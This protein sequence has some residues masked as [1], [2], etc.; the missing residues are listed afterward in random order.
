[1]YTYNNVLVTK[2]ISVNK[3]LTLEYEKNITVIKGIETICIP[4]VNFI[5]G[6]YKINN[7]IKINENNNIKINE[8]NSIKINENTGI[9]TIDKNIALGNYSFQIEYSVNEYNANYL[10][11]FTVIYPFNYNASLYEFNYGENFKIEP[12]IK[13]EFNKLS[14]F[15]ILPEIDGILINK[16][17]GILTNNIL[18]VGSN[19][20][21]V[22]LYILNINCF[23][24][25]QLLNTILKINILPVIKYS[26]T[27]INIKYGNT[28]L[29]KVPL[30]YPEN[31]IFYSDSNII[32]LNE[33][34][35]FSII[36][37][38]DV[39]IYYFDIIYEINSIKTTTTIKVIINPIFEYKYSEFIFD[40]NNEYFTDMPNYYPKNGIFSIIN[41]PNGITMQK[42]GIINV[43]K[44]T[45]IGSYNLSILYKVNKINLTNTINVKILPQ[46]YYKT[47][48]DLSQYNSYFIGYYK[49][50]NINFESF[51]EI[52]Q[53]EKIINTNKPIFTNKGYFTVQN[54]LC[55][56]NI[57]G[58]NGIM[59]LKNINIGVYCF[60]VNYNILNNNKIYK[61]QALITPLFKYNINNYNKKF[62]DTFTTKPPNVYPEG[63]L[64]YFSETYDFFT[65]DFN[66]G[67]ITCISNAEIN[68]YKIIVFYELNGYIS[69]NE[70]LFTVFPDTYIENLEITNLGKNNIKIN[71]YYNGL[72]IENYD[73]LLINNSD[74]L[75]NYTIEILTDTI[76][77]FNINLNA[78]YKNIMFPINFTIK[79]LPTIN[80]EKEIYYIDFG[81]TYIINKPII[82]YS[83]GYFEIINKIKG[84][85][86]DKLSGEIY[87]F[88]KLSVNNYLITINYILNDVI[89]Q[90]IVN[91]I[92]KPIIEYTLTTYEFYCGQIIKSEI[93]KVNPQNGKFS[94]DTNNMNID[95]NNMNID[96]NNGTIYFNN[97]N[98]GLY[99]FNVIYTLNSIN[100]SVN[101]NFLIK[102]IINYEEKYFVNYG[103]E[104]LINPLV[105]NPPNYLIK[106]TNLPLNIILNKNT[107]TIIVL[108]N[109][110]P[111]IYLIELKYIVNDIE[112]I[113]NIN[114]IVDPFLEKTKI[115][116]IIHGN[117]EIINLHNSEMNIM[118]N[119]VNKIDKK[120]FYIKHNKL[121]INNLDIGRYTLKVNYK[122]NKLSDE[123]EYIINVNPNLVYKEIIECNYGDKIE[124]LPIEYSPSNGYFKLINNFFIINKFGCIT[125]KQNT[126]LTINIYDINVE[127][128]F[129]KI[130][131]NCSLQVKIN[132][133][134]KYDN[135]IYEGIQ[136]ETL[137]ISPQNFLPK[138]LLFSVEPFGEINSL[139]N[140]KLTNLNIGKYTLKVNYDI[141][142]IFLNVLIK[143]I[144]FYDDNN[145][146]L[147]FGVNKVFIP[148][149]SQNNGKFYFKHNINGFII[150]ENTGII[151][152][153]NLLPDVYNIIVY[154][155]YENIQV[156]TTL[157]IKVLPVLKYNNNNLL[158]KYKTKI[159]I[160][161]PIVNP[162]G[163]IFFTDINKNNIYLDKNNGNISIDDAN[164]GNYNIIINYLY[165]KQVISHTI[166]FDIIPDIAYESCN[167]IFYNGVENKIEKPNVNPNNGKFLLNCDMYLSKYII[168][169]NNGSMIISSNIN[170]GN[171]DFSVLYEHS[172]IQYSTKISLNIYP[173]LFYNNVITEYQ[174][175]V[176]IVEPNFTVTNHGIYDFYLV[177]SNLIIYSDGKITNFNCLN[178]G[179][180]KIYVNYKYQ[181]KTYQ[182]YFLC[183]IEPI[184][185][186]N[187]KDKTIYLYPNN[188]EL[189]YDNKYFEF[190][191]NNIIYKNIYDNIT[192]P[193]TY[194]LNNVSKKIFIQYLAKP[195]KVFDSEINIIYNTNKIINSYV[196]LGIISS[197]DKP[198]NLKIDNLNLNVENLDIGLYSFTI[199]Y[200]V[201]NLTFNQNIKLTIFPKF[202]YQNKYFELNSNFGKIC[203]NPI[204][205]P[206]NG[207]VYMK[208]FIKNFSV[209]N[210]GIISLFNAIPNF[211]NLTIQYTVNNITSYDTVNI[212]C[213][214]TLT[215]ESNSYIIKYGQPFIITNFKC[216]PQSG[217]FTSSISI[218]NYNKNEIIF[219]YLQNLNIGTHNINL[220]Y[221][222]NNIKATL[223]ITVYIEPTI[224]YLNKNQKTIYG[225]SIT[226]DAPLLSH[227]NGI[228][229]IDIKS[230]NI[231][232]KSDNIDIKSDNIDIK[233]DNIDIKSDNID[234]LDDGSINISSK[235]DIGN[236]VLIISYSI[237][238]F[239]ITDSIILIVDP[240]LYYN[241]NMFTNIFNKDTTKYNINAPKFYPHGGTFYID[242]PSQN[243]TINKNNGII[244][245]DNLNIGKYNF[246]VFYKFKKNIL[247]TSLTINMN[248]YVNYIL[249]VINIKYKTLHTIDQPETS[250]TDGTFYSKNLP[251]GAVLDLK[252]G[253]ILLNQRELIEVGFYN[254]II[255]YT[256]NNLT[257][258]ANIYINVTM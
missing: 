182:T 61:Y 46:F 258:T 241:E 145:T 242:T 72:L 191:N 60:D 106:S 158:L 81:K 231:D 160:I 153:I 150:D 54:P 115:H 23:S 71:N 187:F 21:N 93:P 247:K 136:N 67:E 40:H 95:T 250:T 105:L 44:N 161:M 51:N 140:I 177:N 239:I 243:I 186:P 227:N 219:D 129:N 152:V 195:I 208:H 6:K 134:L 12:N 11:D 183:Q 221:I 141:T 27:L 238:T 232:I 209:N 59:T 65:I 96:T 5:G 26:E 107:G 77:I 224:N 173:Y 48:Y 33:D 94:I 255:N 52:F 7:N 87:V 13:P 176:L 166:T 171:Y 34:G 128:I 217:Q 257:T 204:M 170:V 172:K 108:D 84:I 175:N 236:Y 110:I 246:N 56:V 24:N 203:E 25:G 139:G 82:S 90:V 220:D 162:L 124:I 234:I 76:G 148:S 89:V 42:N 230:N 112:S 237:D 32:I 229:I 253:S 79:V 240:Y 49:N 28:Y 1:M 252:T 245:L 126:I 63:G 256:I 216:Y 198:H 43:N 137:N 91:I 104:L 197:D 222:Y 135:D 37:N 102:P 155:C 19:I 185:I 210:N 156:D 164:I 130:K 100:V 144:F 226:I 180:Y 17:N 146:I 92:I 184:I 154:Y 127:Y 109:C 10:L 249:S 83:N 35:S 58:D 47:I 116:K 31:G 14:E 142:S 70:I 215:L 30:M 99:N 218:S 68:I 200:I 205:E 39:N 151:K 113:T 114:I 50:K 213:K 64:F 69:Y 62:K 131:T 29:S 194:T 88:D 163:G 202:Y 45:P 143:P 138:N 74:I 169:N 2:K 120:K 98:V 192:I 228:F 178:V 86:I 168:L 57:N 165:N 73:I 190:K 117:S 4:N 111:N 181:D 214:P 66:S 196:Q 75:T 248:P 189:E 16:N 199:N 159:P 174:N 121:Y 78:S 212:C 123:F 85:T 167:F 118:Y 188:G 149:I 101:I 233:S 97:T 201:N 193:I 235:L 206:K 133:L 147:D 41:Q 80:Y 223:N 157:N 211:Y 125:Q 55:S 122:I 251:K 20:L 132:P 103:S 38:I 244:E 225:K 22:G 3:K 36:E 254:I 53:C 119:I 15:Y 207:K 18:N 8:N 9:I 179:T